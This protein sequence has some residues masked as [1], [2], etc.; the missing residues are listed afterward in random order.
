[1]R[2]RIAA[3][4]GGITLL[5]LGVAGTTTLTAQE[6]GAGFPGLLLFGNTQRQHVADGLIQPPA[7][8]LLKLL[9]LQGIL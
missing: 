3:L 9:P 2:L 8:N 1:M 4:W 5:G 7:E 6:P